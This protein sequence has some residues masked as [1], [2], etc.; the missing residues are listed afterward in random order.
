MDKYESYFLD[1][2]KLYIFVTTLK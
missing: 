1:K 2:A